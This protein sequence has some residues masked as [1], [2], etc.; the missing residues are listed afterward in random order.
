M[1]QEDHIRKS[2]DI[3]AENYE[4]STRR[5]DFENLNDFSDWLKTQL[6]SLEATHQGFAT[7]SSVRS[8][9]KR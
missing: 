9:L 1:L 8:F 5:I 3:C 6:R 4:D 7:L 2:S